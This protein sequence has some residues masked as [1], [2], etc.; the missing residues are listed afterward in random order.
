M[1]EFNK[2]FNVEGP[3][4]RVELE[5][6]LIK[7]FN[8]IGYQSFN[9][10]GETIQYTFGAEFQWETYVYESNP[11]PS[12]DLALANFFVKYV[13]EKDENEFDDYRDYL[14]Y[15]AEMKEFCS[16]LKHI[17]QKVYGG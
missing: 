10:L 5:D 2:L 12:P 17:V 15:K 3:F 9:F 11:C 14:E 16:I 13:K 7:E 4:K 1:E 8:A 6:E